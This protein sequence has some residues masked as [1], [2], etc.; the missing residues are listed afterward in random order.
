MPR[1]S[2]NVFV[3]FCPERF[4]DVHV[5]VVDLDAQILV[6]VQ[7]E[8]LLRVR[9]QEKIVHD[10]PH[11]HVALGRTKQIVRRDEPH[12]VGREDEVLHVDRLLGGV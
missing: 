9:A 4:S 3:S 1:K 8:K 11:P 2:L 10:D 12:I 6:R 5:R 7:V